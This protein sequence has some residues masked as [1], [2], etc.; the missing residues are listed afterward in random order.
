MCDETPFRRGDICAIGS[1]TER[2][3]VVLHQP[4]Y[5]PVQ[6][7]SGDDG[8]DRYDDARAIPSFGSKH[9]R[10]K[11]VKQYDDGELSEFYADVEADEGFGEGVRR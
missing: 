8:G 1:A 10:Y 3:S 7:N 11:S 4:F 6:R 5:R 9:T 2:C